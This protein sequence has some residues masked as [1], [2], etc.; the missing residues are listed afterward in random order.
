MALLSGL[1][2]AWAVGMLVCGVLWN[3][4]E[5][6]A[7]LAL[8]GSGPAGVGGFCEVTFWRAQTAGAP[9]M[10]AVYFE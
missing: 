7:V 6:A 4:N 1:V 2:F 9:T 3:F 10:T 5:R 8:W